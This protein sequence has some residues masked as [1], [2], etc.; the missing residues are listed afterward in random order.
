M[1][2]LLSA[3]EFWGLVV[4][5]VM[6]AAKPV[7]VS[8]QVGAGPDLVHDALNSFTVPVGHVAMLAD[9]LSLLTSREDLR[10][11]MGEE[12]ARRIRSWD[13]QADLE[14]LRSALGWVVGCRP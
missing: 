7:I 6:N 5:E 9:R 8:D 10:H 12:S 13:F 14:G 4:N 1:F 11:V 3:R 2:V